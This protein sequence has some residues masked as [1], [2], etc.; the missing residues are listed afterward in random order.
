MKPFEERKARFVHLGDRL[1]AIGRIRDGMLTVEEAARE[2]GVTPDDVVGWQQLHAFERTV[3]FAELRQRD[4]PQMQVLN[5]R[6]QRLADLITA[7]ERELRELH[8]EFIAGAIAS[9]EFG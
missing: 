1:L 5:R 7:A 3:S 2:L 6:A 9:K 4:S 8:Q